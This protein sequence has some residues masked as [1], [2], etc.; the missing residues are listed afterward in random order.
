[1]P[2]NSSLR[3]RRLPSLGNEALQWVVNVPASL[4]PTGK[5]QRHF[6]ATRQQAEVECELLKTRKFNFGHSLSSLSPAQIAEAVA[7]YERLERGAPGLSLSHAVTESLALYQARN[8]SVLTGLLFD[9]FV[10]SKGEVSARYR[11]ELASTFRRLNSL[12]HILASDVT[13]NEI[14]VALIEFP[15]AHRNAALRYLRAAFNFGIRSGWLKESPIKSLEFTKIVRD[16]VEI[17]PPSTVEKLLGDA[18]ANDVGLLPFLVLSFYAGVRPDGELQKL[19]WSDIDLRAE[20]HHVAIRPTVAKKRR[21]RW[22]DLS[23]N[24]IAWLGEYR[25][26]GGKTDGFIVPFSASTLRRKRRR[27]ARAVGLDTWPQQ[28]ARH[29][30]CSAWLRQH[31]DINK[32]VLQAGH[33]SPTVLWN[34]YYQAMSPEDAAAF[35]NI[36]PPVR[37]AR[38]IIP[39]EGS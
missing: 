10:E 4:S 26:R 22:I 5:R 20:E 33:E 36:F 39:F 35:W 19:I 17:I 2:R 24:A 27:N 15:P 30:Y 9:K 37:E 18:L 38:Q 13:A 16:A 28:G 21:K 6:F 3:P 7:C 32:L 12:H 1:M 31:G 29:T 23:D 25:A 14:E 8:A 11:Q 34:H